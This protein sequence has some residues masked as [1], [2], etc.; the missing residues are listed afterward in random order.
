MRSQ[1]WAKYKKQFRIVCGLNWVK[2]QHHSKVLTLFHPS[3][4]SNVRVSPWI[5]SENRLQLRHRQRVKA[6]IARVEG[7]LHKP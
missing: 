5:T 3:V 4:S 6:N 7:H 1:K 2:K